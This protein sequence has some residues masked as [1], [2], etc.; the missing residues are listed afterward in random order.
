M[1]AAM[2]ARTTN[3]RFMV[4]ALIAPFH[5]P[6]RLAEDLVVLDNLSRGRVDV[7]VA[8]GY[9][10]HEFA[11]F[12]VPRRERAARVTETVATLRAAFTGEPFE[13]RGRTVHVTPAPFRPG[14]PGLMLGGSSEPAARRAARIA[15]GFIP[16][17]P[18]V[19]EFY[20]D[21][22]QQL[23]RPDPGECP[24]GENRTVALAEDVDRGWAE[25]GPFFL[26]ETNAYGAWLAEADM[27][28]P[29]HQVDDVDALR[30]GR[31]YAVLTPDQLVEELQA[32]PFPF[33]LFHP[34]CGGMPPDLAWSSLRLFEHEVLPAFT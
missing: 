14:G 23:G 34:M 26:H 32:A 3:V 17:V 29:Y 4:A 33:A 30:A 28:A 20:R 10:N 6:L 16:S 12:D 2:A 9:A 1:L 11:M 18:E 27:G 31:Q 8:G 22:V 15:D 21:E 24:I 13:H 25:M 5:D 7:I 19:W